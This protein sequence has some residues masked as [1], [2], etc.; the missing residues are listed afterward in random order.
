MKEEYKRFSQ[1]WRSSLADIQSMKGIIRKIEAPDDIVAPQ[2]IWESGMVPIDMVNAWFQKDQS[3]QEANSPPIDFIRIIYRPFLYSRRVSHGI[4]NT[5][6]QGYISTLFIKA[7]LSREGR[8]FPTGVVTVPRDLLAPNAHLGYVIGTIDDHDECLTRRPFEPIHAFIGVHKDEVNQYHSSWS[9]FTEQCQELLDSVTP[10][11]KEG[12]QWVDMKQS[13][14]T[15]D[16]EITGASLHIMALYETIIGGGKNDGLSLYRKFC[17]TDILPVTNMADSLPS[18]QFNLSTFAQRLGHASDQYALADAQ[19]DALSHLMKMQPGEI[20]AVNG[21]PGTGKT[22][23]VLSAVASLWVEAALRND[24]IPPVIFATSTN[25]QAV[26]NIIDA[27]GKDFSNGD[28]PFSGRWI[29]KLTSFGSYYASQHKKESSVSVGPEGIYIGEEFFESIE[30]G[31][32]VTQAENE[33][34]EYARAAFS[35]HGQMSLEKAVDLLHG[36]MKGMQQRLDALYVLWKQI[37]E[38]W[39]SAFKWP[40]S[41]HDLDCLNQDIITSGGSRQI[42]HGLQNEWLLW[43]EQGSVWLHLFSWL[44]PIRNFRNTKAALF[45]QRK[46]LPLEETSPALYREIK[47]FIGSSGTIDDITENLARL[48]QRHDDKV[49]NLQT[50]RDNIDRWISEIN[51]LGL[52]DPY[53]DD[54]LSL[55]E[56]DQQLDRTIRFTLF[57]L[58]VHYWEGQWLLEMKRDGAR[59][60]KN[61]AWTSRNELIARWQRRMKLTPCAVSTMFMLPAKGKMKSKEG[62]YLFDFI[63]LLIVDEAGQVTT[64]VGASAFSL[65]KKALVIGDTLQIEPIWGVPENVDYG[66][67]VHANIIS[68]NDG[69]QAMDQLTVHGRTASGG[70]VM[71]VAQSATQ[72]QYDAD[73]SRGLY[74]YEHRR[75]FNEIIGFC[76]T[77]CYHGK[78]NPMRGSRPSDF[79]DQ[80]PAV[81]YQHVNGVCESVNGGSRK[82]ITEAEIIAQWIAQHEKKLLAAYGQTSL[83]DIIGIVTPFN[84]QQHA[85]IEACKALGLDAGTSAGMTVGTV[86]ALQGAERPVIIF[87]T[88]YTKRNNGS[89]IDRSRSMLNVAVSRAKNTLLV[90]GD[91]DTLESAPEGSPR[92][93]LADFLSDNGRSL[94]FA[95][96][97][98]IQAASGYGNKRILQDYDEHDA[99]LE[100]ILT[101]AQREI[102]LVSPWVKIGRLADAGLETAFSNAV[103]RGVK[104]VV[105]TVPRQDEST[106]GAFPGKE[107]ILDYLSALGVEVVFV[108]RVHCKTLTADEFIYCDGSFNW[109]SASRHDG[110]KN[111]ERSIAL[112]GE[113]VKEDIQAFLQTMRK[114]SAH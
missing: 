18:S 80:L 6:N 108:R 72:F 63:D 88:V 43:L 2:D 35:D 74:L 30:S 52:R 13:L 77:L 33:Y 22:T 62:E 53:K 47:E 9:L 26:T 114:I 68:P 84:A 104:V 40:L 27:F 29:N 7:I 67:L 86:N 64:E 87:S 46:I 70:S 105:Y 89:F 51:S 11:L 110:Y 50:C 101:R 19:R 83:K 71:K 65:A 93:L 12:A 28:G 3:L 15:R 78:L 1:Y 42:I 24:G 97:R 34:L 4:R 21:P 61:V 111:Y 73:L 75:C 48:K 32:F 10:G 41:I 57:R 79:S 23:L 45:M 90:F 91:L 44:A 100:E 109:L 81:G 60:R 99:Y 55:Q 76:N 49:A 56:A 96:Y 58:A 20:L 31:D 112:E 107:E 39:E 8:I 17:A 14:L 94:D 103:K 25:N 66:N 16:I 54:I 95:Q 5:T 38:S 59:I 113:T 98:P 92:R 106:S 37:V 36:E 102:H 85:V 69:H 82:N